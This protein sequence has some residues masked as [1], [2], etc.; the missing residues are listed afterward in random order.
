MKKL[1][2]AA[3]LGTIAV[4]PAQGAGR[5]TWPTFEECVAWAES[6][7]SGQDGTFTYVCSPAADGSWELV[8]SKAGSTRER[9]AHGGQGQ[10]KRA[11]SR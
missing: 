5:D 7:G 4:A 10:L 9:P 2:L 3:I 1:A 8:W 6:A 11:A